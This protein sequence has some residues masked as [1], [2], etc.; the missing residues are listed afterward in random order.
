MTGGVHDFPFRSQN[1]EKIGLN[2]MLNQS[3]NL[4][5]HHSNTVNIFISIQ[6]WGQADYTFVTFGIYVILVMPINL[7]LVNERERITIGIANIQLIHLRDQKDQ[8]V[9]ILML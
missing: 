5:S 7:D 1:A 9:N 4:S 2:Q 3:I 6:A 8:K